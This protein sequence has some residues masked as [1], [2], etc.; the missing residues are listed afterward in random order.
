M[1]NNAKQIPD[2]EADPN[3]ISGHFEVFPSGPGS[4]ATVAFMFARK[5]Y[6]FL[7]ET[8]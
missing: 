8:S 1:W 3:T 4:E 6:K 5:L 2:C 7:K